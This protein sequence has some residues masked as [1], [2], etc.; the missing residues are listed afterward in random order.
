MFW[1]DYNR[2]LGIR[3]EDDEQVRCVDLELLKAKTV[4]KISMVDGM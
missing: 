3:I 2:V 4:I 1:V